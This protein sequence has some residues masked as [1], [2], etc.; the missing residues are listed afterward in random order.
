MLRT[1][2]AF[3]SYFEE[4]YHNKKVGEEI[5]VKSFSQDENILIQDQ[6]LSKV[7]LIKEGIAKCYFTEENGKEYIVEF[8]GNGEILGEVELIKNISCLCGV[9]A[10]SEVTVYETNIVYF[11][12]LIKND[13]ALNHLL[14]DSFAE[15]IINTSSRASYQQLYTVEHTL[16][17]LLNMQSKQGI[18][19]SKEDMAAY[20][21]IT[22]RTLN[23]IL[24]DLK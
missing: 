13:L 15:R 2:Q 18:Q 9:K 10:V 24:K 21:G 3:S 11:K 17:Q 12:S 20:L 7:M 6:S 19:I 16:T 22:V 5:I 4:L 14:L 23:R 8:L 1:N